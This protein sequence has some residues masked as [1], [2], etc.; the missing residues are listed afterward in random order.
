MVSFNLS[1]KKS[2]SKGYENG[3]IWSN[4]NTHVIVL[5]KT[6]WPRV[7]CSRKYKM[8]GE[9]EQRHTTM[10]GHS[11]SIHQMVPWAPSQILFK[12]LSYEPYLEKIKC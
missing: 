8:N 6:E 7:M 12:L 5:T 9:R 2:S 4:G 3:Q 11:M 10:E 1:Y